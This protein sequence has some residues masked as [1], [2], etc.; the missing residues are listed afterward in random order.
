MLAQPTILVVEPDRMV[1]LADLDFTG[2]YLSI[3]ITGI[4]AVRPVV[5]NRVLPGVEIEGAV[6][7]CGVQRGE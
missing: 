4:A 5:E 7:R 3:H 1:W 2:C 6:Q